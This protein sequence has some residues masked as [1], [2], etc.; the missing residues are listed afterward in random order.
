MRVSK[1]GSRIEAVDADG[2]CYAFNVSFDR[3]HQ[4]FKFSSQALHDVAVQR[5]KRDHDL[6]YDSPAYQYALA[7]LDVIREDQANEWI[8]YE[9]ESFSELHDHVDAN[10]YLWEV[11]PDASE[12]VSLCNEVTDHVDR[13]LSEPLTGS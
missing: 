9:I 13:L 4:V 1:D 5:A 12:R 8:P 3:H 6:E 2:I 7:I 10:A 11:I